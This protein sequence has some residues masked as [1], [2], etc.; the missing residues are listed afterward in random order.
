[1][2]LELEERDVNSYATSRVRHPLR[3][4]VGSATFVGS[5]STFWSPVSRSRLEGDEFYE[6]LGHGFM[7]GT[8]SD[9]ERSFLIL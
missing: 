1:M 7:S 6:D 8:R 2:E 5:E 4:G 9:E 3:G